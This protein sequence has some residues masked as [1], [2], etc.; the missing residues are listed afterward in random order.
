MSRGVDTA[1]CCSPKPSRLRCSI[2]GR[3]AEDFRAALPDY[4]EGLQRVVDRLVGHDEE[5]A[6]GS[7]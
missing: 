3:L 1:R 5:P 4:A 6:R 7:S 2:P